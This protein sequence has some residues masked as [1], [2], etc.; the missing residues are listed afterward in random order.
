MVCFY[1]ID[2]D[3]KDDNLMYASPIPDDSITG[4]A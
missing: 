2:D 3:L 1:S 4:G